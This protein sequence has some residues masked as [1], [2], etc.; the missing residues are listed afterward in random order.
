MFLTQVINRSSVEY[1]ASMWFGSL[2]SI[3][4]ETYDRYYVG[5][6]N[7]VNYQS[8]THSARQRLTPFCDNSDNKRD[9]EWYLSNVAFET[10]TSSVDFI[11]FGLLR[12]KSDWCGRI[13]KDSGRIVLGTCRPQLYGRSTDN[14]IFQLTQE[15]Y[16]KI[17]G[18][19]DVLFIY[20]FV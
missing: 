7:V 13:L 18:E 9:I 2:Q 3:V 1:I 5:V 4:I 19:G 17:S 14:M 12:V 8:R 6:D 16:L 15:G 11:A 20:R 10:S